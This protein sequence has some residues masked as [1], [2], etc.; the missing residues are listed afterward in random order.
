M[1]HEWKTFAAE[2]WIGTTCTAIDRLLKTIEEKGY[3][4]TFTNVVPIGPDNGCLVFITGK[5]NIEVG[6][7]E[8][9]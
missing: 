2:A 9:G 3:E 1:K 8:P 5:R 4:P 7:R 6:Y